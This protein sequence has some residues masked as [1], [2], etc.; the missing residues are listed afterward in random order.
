MHREIE[1]LKSKLNLKTFYVFENSL[2]FSNLSKS[3]SG[4]GY[5]TPEHIKQVFPKQ[6]EDFIIMSCGCKVMNKS[7]I[8]P[9][10]I[11]MGYNEES[12]FLY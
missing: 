7:Y 9:M 6:M 12:I 11:E 5:I 4:N 1:N 3:N 2:Q 8:K 10:L